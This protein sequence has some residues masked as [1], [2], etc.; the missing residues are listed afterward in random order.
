MSVLGTWSRGGINGLLKGM[1][2]N[3]PSYYTDNACVFIYLGMC[4]VWVRCILSSV[5]TWVWVWRSKVDI[6][7][8]PGV[9]PPLLF[10]F[11]FLR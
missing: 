9:V 5:G 10:L 7:C 1:T 3:S 2:L 6:Q 8:L 11:L 4:W